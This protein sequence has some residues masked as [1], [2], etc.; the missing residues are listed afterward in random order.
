MADALQT[1]KGPTT[2]V[3]TFSWFTKL[4][5]VPFSPTHPHLWKCTS[6]KNDD[7][8]VNYRKG[9]H[10]FILRSGSSVVLVNPSLP[11]PPQPWV[12]CALV[13]TIMEDPKHIISFHTYIQYDGSI[14]F[15]TLG[16]IETYHLQSCCWID[17]KGYICPKKDEAYSIP[18]L[19]V[20]CLQ[21]GFTN[22][23]L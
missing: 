16:N 11:P 21:K 17:F 2:I 9:H 22:W 13:M 14:F 5:N 20:E 10:F 19:P 23:I 3:I 1:I 15:K 12:F 18:S 6:I 7:S 4:R 8:P